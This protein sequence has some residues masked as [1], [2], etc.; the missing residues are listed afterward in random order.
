M[1]N[2]FLLLF[3]CFVPIEIHASE[4][5]MLGFAYDC[6]AVR[7]ND[8]LATE[9]IKNHSE[10]TANMNVAISN[11]K[12]RNINRTKDCLYEL[13]K[14]EP[15]E[16]RNQLALELEKWTEEIILHVTNSAENESSSYC[17]EAISQLNDQKFDILIK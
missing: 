15:E 2:L 9:C 16:K 4:G 12:L 3:L 17:D 11:W 14:I 10:L 7:I 1:K 13:S 6:N 5:L 8:V